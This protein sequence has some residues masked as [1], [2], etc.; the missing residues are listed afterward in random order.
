MNQQQNP[1]PSQPGSTSGS[2]PV[3]MQ[4]K[5]GKRAEKFLMNIW[6]PLDV[7]GKSLMGDY[8][9]TVYL[10]IQDAIALS[11]LLQIPDI[12][13][14]WVLGK[15][16]SDFTVCLSESP[17][18]ASRYACFIIVTSDFLQWILIAGRIIGR[19]WADFSEMRTGRGGGHGSNQP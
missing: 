14:R 12:I 4:T 3:Q 16:F 9:K 2:Q 5:M 17:W 19:F 13:G 18:G 7:L 6:E 11:V 15:S 10:S 8:W 1:P